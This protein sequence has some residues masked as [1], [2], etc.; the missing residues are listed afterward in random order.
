[1]TGIDGIDPGVPPSG[2]GCDAVGGWWFHLRR[3]AQC[4]HA[5]CCD[6]SAGQPAPGPADRVP[7]DWTEHLHR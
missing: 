4:G 2:T 5:G 7:A 3:R 6:S 1:M